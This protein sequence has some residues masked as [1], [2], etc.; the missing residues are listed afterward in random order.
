ME[1]QKNA[2]RR[3]DIRQIRDTRRYST[4]AVSESRDLQKAV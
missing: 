2:L 3:V 4:S 1:S